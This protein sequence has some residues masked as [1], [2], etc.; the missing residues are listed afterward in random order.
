M[1]CPGNSELGE[2]DI[3]RDVFQRDSLSPLVFV[4]VL[5]RLR[6][7]ELSFQEAKRRLIIFYLWM[8]RSYIVAIKKD[9]IR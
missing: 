6:L 3:K 4:S 7:Y 8:M 2:V 5:I 9:W 1:L